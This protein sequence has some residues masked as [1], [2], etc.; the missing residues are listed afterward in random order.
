MFGNQNR[1][2][3]AVRLVVLASDIEYVSTD[4][5]SDVF[6][7]LRQTLSIIEFIDIVDVSRCLLFC[8]GI[9]DIINIKAQLLMG[10]S[11]SFRWLSPVYIQK[12]G[13]LEQEPHQDEGKES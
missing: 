2:A 6:K 8:F 11:T 1:H 10:I 4:D 3:R 12:S 13:F 9:T 5:I 7:N